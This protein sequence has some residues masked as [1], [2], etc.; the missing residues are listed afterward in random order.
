MGGV[1]RNS[2]KRSLKPKGVKRPR[3]ALKIH[4]LKDKRSQSIM[5]EGGAVFW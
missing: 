4:K 5:E 3:K 2:L 1:R